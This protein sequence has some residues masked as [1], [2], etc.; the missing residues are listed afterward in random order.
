M[1]GHPTSPLPLRE[2]NVDISP[3]VERAKQVVADA[4]EPIFQNARRHRV[5]AEIL[6]AAGRATAKHGEQSHLPDGTGPDEEPLQL[7]GNGR[8][9]DLALYCKY[10]TDKRAGTGEV[11]W[12]DILIEEIAE[13]SEQDDLEALRGELLDS[14]A[15]IVNWV[16]A[17]DKRREE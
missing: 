7:R 5:A 17:I 14:A 2:F 12:F 13:A 9:S 10:Q 3:A 4:M 15:V 11:T 8:N 16:L 1:A 6:E